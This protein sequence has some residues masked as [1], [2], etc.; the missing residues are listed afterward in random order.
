MVSSAAPKVVSVSTRTK[1]NTHRCHFFASFTIFSEVDVAIIDCVCLQG[2][3]A[4]STAYSPHIVLSVG[5]GFA[6]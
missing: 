2:L 4:V 5:V 6:V 3:H 1:Y